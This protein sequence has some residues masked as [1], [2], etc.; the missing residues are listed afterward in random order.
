[1]RKSYKE[2]IKSLLPAI[3]FMVIYKFYSYKIA[4]VVG[5]IVGAVIYI[6]KYRKYNKLSSMDKLGLFGLIIQ[7]ILSS[8]AS[9]PK[10]YFVYPL[11]E[12]I[13]F[14]A[15]F[16]GSLF[17][18]NSIISFFAK[19]YVSEDNIYEIMKPTYYKLTLIWGVFFLF[20]AIIK[21]VGIMSWSFEL[22]YY[23]NWILGTPVSL[24]LLWFSFKY[25]NKVYKSQSV[26]IETVNGKS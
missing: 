2:I 5:L 21:A 23:I 7:C 15:V 25:P 16:I 18:K 6:S 20:R 17:T 26:E 8:L 1:M 11:I 19:D 4:L 3:L 13:M 9:N 12:S 22:L 10:V 24:G 14:A